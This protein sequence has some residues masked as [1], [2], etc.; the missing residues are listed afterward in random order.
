MQFIGVDEVPTSTHSAT[1][2]WLD[3]F[4]V[5]AIKKGFSLLKYTFQFAIIILIPSI[6]YRFYIRFG[7]IP[8]IFGLFIGVMACWSYYEASTKDPGYIEWHHFRTP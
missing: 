2:S 6:S 3:K 7:E 4:A 1:M 8:P 5:S